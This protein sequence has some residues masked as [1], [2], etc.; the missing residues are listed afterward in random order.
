ML[1]SG[2]SCQ[3]NLA[4]VAGKIKSLSL[5]HGVQQQAAPNGIYM[6]VLFHLGRRSAA[7]FFILPFSGREGQR[8]GMAK[9][10]HII[11]LCSL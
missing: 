9:R 7:F 10:Q 4:K 3:S 8:Q 6:P 11:H 1:G 5:G 2:K